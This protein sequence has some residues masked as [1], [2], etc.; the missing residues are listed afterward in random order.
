MRSLDDKTSVS[1][2]VEGQSNQTESS[3]RQYWRQQQRM[4]RVSSGGG[5]RIRAWVPV[6]NQI[7]RTGMIVWRIRGM[8]SQVE[9]THSTVDEISSCWICQNQKYIHIVTLQ[10]QRETTTNNWIVLNILLDSLKSTELQLLLAVVIAFNLSKTHHYDWNL[11][12]YFTASKS[13]K[14]LNLFGNKPQHEVFSPR[15]F[16]LIGHSLRCVRPGPDW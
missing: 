3:Q 2:I 12:F 6:W 14:G 4:L 1:R 10:S 7:S 8:A 16:G 11:R 9:N 13:R 15:R 5:Q